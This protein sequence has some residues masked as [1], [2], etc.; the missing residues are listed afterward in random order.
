MATPGQFELI[1]LTNAVVHFGESITVPSTANGPV[2]VE[3]SFHKTFAGRL[4]SFLY[5]TV[6]LNLVLT[7]PDHTK[8]SF[9]VIPGM[10]ESGFLLSPMVLD[11]R[12]FAE[13]ASGDYRQDNGKFDVES[14]AITA[15]TTGGSTIY[16]GASMPVRFYRLTYPYQDFKWPLPA[17]RK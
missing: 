15:E 7:L 14:F 13:L 6:A 8:H 2:W 10:T 17:V 1:P 4:A 11:A 5:K 9:R 12:G 3:I 16:Y